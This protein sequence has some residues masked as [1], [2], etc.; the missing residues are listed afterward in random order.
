M[1]ASSYTMQDGSNLE[2]LPTCSMRSTKERRRPIPFHGLVPLRILNGDGI[3]PGRV[4]QSGTVDVS[5]KM[6]AIQKF[7][8]SAKGQTQS[9]T[10]YGPVSNRPQAAVDARVSTGS[11]NG[12]CI[13]G[14]DYLG[15]LHD[16]VLT[17]DGTR[18]KE[19]LK[20]RRQKFMVSRGRRTAAGGAVQRRR[21]AAAYWA[22]RRTPE[23]LHV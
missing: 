22:R 9:S 16:K 20:L 18:K 13:T 15:K 17:G 11:Q 3:R 10:Q 1:Y 19:E 23:L 8:D 5:D 7:T 2:A 21:R 6:W 4:E 12:G 14:Y